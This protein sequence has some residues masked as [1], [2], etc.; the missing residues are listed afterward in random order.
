MG[1]VLVTVVAS[2]RPLIQTTAAEITLNAGES[3]TVDVAQYAT[4]P[5]ADRGP[6]Q[7]LPSPGV[8]D[9][10]TASAS[11]TQITISANSGFNGSFM[12]TYRLQDATAD[13]ERE[14]QGT[15]TATVRDKPDAPTAMTAESNTSQSAILS[16]T[17]GAANGAPITG[18]TVTDHTQGDSK[19]CGVNTQCIFTGR[20][21]GQN[22]TFSVTATNEVGES[23]PSNQAS[24]N[25]D[26]EP[27]TPAAPTA[28]PGDHE[29]TVT[30]T[31]PHNEGSPI[32]NYEV[33][34]R[35]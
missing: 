16:W 27:E 25:I 20:T 11:G 9:G 26:I 18:Y 12:V 22:H 6:L 34:L 7:V 33:S 8:T 32:T 29:I 4:N 28:T 31:E 3:Q 14:V 10:G 17:A 24:V 21:N 35:G 30:W 13:T 5:F 15:I 23:A 1:S 19:D 2:S